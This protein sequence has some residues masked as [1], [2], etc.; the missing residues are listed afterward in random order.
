MLTPHLAQGIV[1]RSRH[2][3]PN[4]ET[5][6][7]AA[8][9]Q[10]YQQVYSQG[11]RHKVWTRLAGRSRRLL[12]LA[13]IE[14]TYVITGRY[15]A[16][17]QTVPLHQIRGSQ[18]RSSDFDLDFYPLQAHDQARWISVAAAWHMGKMLPPVE[19]VQVGE[20]YFVRDGHHRISVARTL[21]QEDIEAVVRVWQ[22]AGPLPW[23]K[24]KL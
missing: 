14:A 15:G 10:L 16:G 13:E 3:R 5:Q 9:K 22:V 24:P 20:T 19:L 21:G 23:D 18:G 4:P 17:L 6:A 8:A 1:V 2:D 12:N 7:M 11:W